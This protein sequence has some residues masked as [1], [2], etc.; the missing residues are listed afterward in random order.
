MN[1]LSAIG[2]M[3]VLSYFW[4][5][6]RVGIA[7]RKKHSLFTIAAIPMRRRVSPTVRS[8][9]SCSL[10]AVRVVQLR[11][12]APAA[13]NCRAAVSGATGFTQMSVPSSKP[14]L[15]VMRGKISRYQ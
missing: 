10:F 12:P 8:Y 3:I 5:R 7:R 1:G 2:G 14:A 9:R 15:R 13:F 11:S 6:R 4:P